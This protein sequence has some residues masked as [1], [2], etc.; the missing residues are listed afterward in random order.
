MSEVKGVIFDFD[1]TL[2]SRM[3]YAYAC[4]HEVL[5]SLRLNIDPIEIEAIVQRCMIWDMQGD[6]NKN[7]VKDKLKEA[8][9]IVLPYDDFNKHWEGLLWRH[10]ITQEDTIET[11]TYLS[12]KYKLAILTNG[13][14]EGQRRKIKQA[15]LTNFFNE[16]NTIISGDYQIFKPDARI[17]H[18]ACEKIH[19]KPEETVYVGDLFHRDVLGAYKA[20]LIPVWISNNPNKPCTYPIKRIDKLK[21]LM[22][23]L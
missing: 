9:N 22:N 23:I 16:D 7:F 8:Y 6:V 5:E 15:K 20:N 17:F 19:T 4:Y 13:P 1:D 21:D 3:Q 11:L 18:L 12:Q 2:A 14:S 10:V